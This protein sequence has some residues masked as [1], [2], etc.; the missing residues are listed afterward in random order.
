MKNRV[1]P[2]REEGYI[3]IKVAL[4]LER[5][6]RSNIRTFLHSGFNFTPVIPSFFKQLNRMAY[7]YSYNHSKPGKMYIRMF[8]FASYLLLSLPVIAQKADTNHYFVTISFYSFGTGTPDSKPL[9]SYISKFKKANKIKSISADHIGP[10]GREGEYK[11]AFTL[12]ELNARQRKLFVKDLKPVV[13]S[14]KER[15]SAKMMLSEQIS[16]SSI[17]ERATIEKQK[18]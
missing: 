1:L 10:L 3:F 11:L 12:K 17:P 14:M 7:F 9:K 16:P 8:I 18:F 13:D 4:I 15:G 6:F 2:S 5:L